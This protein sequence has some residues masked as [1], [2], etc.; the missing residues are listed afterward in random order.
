MTSVSLIK[1]S[2]SAAVTPAVGKS[3]SQPAA[4]DPGTKD[5]AAG[6]VSPVINVDAET[7]VAVL[8]FRDTTTGNETYQ[9]P[10]KTA[11]AE[12]ERQQ[13][14]QEGVVGMTAG[15]QSS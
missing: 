2:P 5:A 1:G 3:E 14:Q 7:G 6:F 9:I 13:R 15:V 12:Y 10:P 11:L 4:A 8:T